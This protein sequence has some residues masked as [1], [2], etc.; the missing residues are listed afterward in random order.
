[1]IRQNSSMTVGDWCRGRWKMK[2]LQSVDSTMTSAN[3]NHRPATILH[4]TRS[5]IKYN[6][7]VKISELTDRHKAHREV[8]HMGNRGNRE[9]TGGKVVNG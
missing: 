2:G 1:M 3:S 5:T 9:G 8:W 7:T 6:M 4:T